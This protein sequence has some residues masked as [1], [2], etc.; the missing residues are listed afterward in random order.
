[1]AASTISCAK[2]IALTPWAEYGLMHFTYHYSLNLYGWSNLQTIY[3]ELPFTESHN[4]S[5]P[6]ITKDWEVDVKEVR[7]TL[8]RNIIQ[9]CRGSMARNRESCKEKCPDI[10]LP[11]VR[12]LIRVEEDIGNSGGWTAIGNFTLGYYT[13]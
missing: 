8:H 7:N 11:S 10:I 13:S 6:F 12:W 2:S 1:V 3:L 9:D 5:D 4:T